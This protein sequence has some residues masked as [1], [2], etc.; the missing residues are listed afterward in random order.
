MPSSICLDQN[1][2]FRLSRSDLW[3]S[4]PEIWSRIPAVSS[5]PARP[6]LSPS[7]I[8]ADTPDEALAVFRTQHKQLSFFAAD[9]AE[10]FQ[11][12]RRFG[13]PLPP[14][15]VRPSSLPVSIVLH[16]MQRSF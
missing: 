13:E 5:K 6:A 3:L 9:T 7:C 11:W 15:T 1:P 10:R 12:L 14:R 16:E 4:R 2:P 8:R